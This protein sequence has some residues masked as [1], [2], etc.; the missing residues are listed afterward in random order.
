MKTLIGLSVLALALS[1]CNGS[2]AQGV[3]A[4][5]V[6]L[7]TDAPVS[8]PVSQPTPQ[9]T[10]QPTSDPQ[11]SPSPSASPQVQDL[12]FIPEENNT[13]AYNLCVALTTWNSSTTTIEIQYNGYYYTLS[14][15]GATVSYTSG[16]DSGDTFQVLDETQVVIGANYCTLNME[17]G[18][19]Q[20]IV[21]NLQGV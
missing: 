7:P 20:S 8:A 15:S 11:P 19:V 21:N 3:Q 18:A 9:P 12:S 1:A 4:D 14:E 10:S 2:G 16:V 5:A 13:V 17:N 6:T